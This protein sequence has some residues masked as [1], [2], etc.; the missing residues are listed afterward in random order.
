MKDVKLD[1]GKGRVEGR[2]GGKE[3]KEWERKCL[4]DLKGKREMEEKK[5][6]WKVRRMEKDYL[7][8]LHGELGEEG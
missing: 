5:E 4:I 6:E 7:I 8:D 1:E 2:T 3:N